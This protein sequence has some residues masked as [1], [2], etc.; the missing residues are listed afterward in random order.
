MSSTSMPAIA[1]H[2]GPFIVAGTPRDASRHTANQRA[3]YRVMAE[4]ESPC[5]KVCVVDPARKLCIGCGRT[6]AEIAGWIGYTPEQR[7][8][9]MA[10]L[11][12]R[13]AALRSSRQN[14]TDAC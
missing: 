7:R 10:A 5:N 3:K 14:K 13:L 2:A 4:I 8:R 1:F 6:L 11:P 12:D 9:V